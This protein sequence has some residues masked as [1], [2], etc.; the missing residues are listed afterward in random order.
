M[1]LRLST[2]IGLAYWNNC[3]LPKTP[4]STKY[5]SHIVDERLLPRPEGSY[6]TGRTASRIRP[7]L[8]SHTSNIFSLGE[9]DLGS[10]FYIHGQ[11]RG[12][13]VGVIVP[14]G[15]ELVSASR[16]AIGTANCDGVS[17]PSLP[18]P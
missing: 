11:Q 5:E 8:Y 9:R 7:I 18:L 12:T 16:G 10:N 6:P 15:E 14:A 1:L 3:T 13:D 2:L 4:P 17:L